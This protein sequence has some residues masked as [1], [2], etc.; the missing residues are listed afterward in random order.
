MSV[1]MELATS[2]SRA[3]RPLSAEQRP[4]KILGTG[5][6]YFGVRLKRDLVEPPQEA[7]QSRLKGSIFVDLSA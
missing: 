1:Y 3:L 4:I 7:S 6:T 2:L 5:G